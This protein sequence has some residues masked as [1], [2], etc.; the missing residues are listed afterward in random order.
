MNQHPLH[1]DAAYASK[2]NS[3]GRWSIAPDAVDRRRHERQRR[4]PEGD[5]Q[6]RLDR[7]QAD[8]AGVRRRYHLRRV[9]SS[10]QAT[11]AIIRNLNGLVEFV[12]RQVNARLPIAREAVKSMQ[13][14]R[15]TWSGA[16]PLPNGQPRP[17]M[18][19]CGAG[20][21]RGCAGD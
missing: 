14:Q 18:G 8:R 2:A 3:A 13:C 12:W 21:W 10:P 15:F 4:Q 20:V 19:R 17:W 1:F 6:S 11:D 16:K 5:R 7:H 9:R